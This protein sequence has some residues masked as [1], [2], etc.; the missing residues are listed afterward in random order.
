MDFDALNALRHEVRNARWA[1]ANA[2]CEAQEAFDAYAAAA[3]R[4]AEA[5][6]W[7]VEADRMVADA[8]AAVEAFEQE[9]AAAAAIW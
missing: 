4:L 6:D 7:I 8:V 2:R 5:N 1:A 3:R 9:A